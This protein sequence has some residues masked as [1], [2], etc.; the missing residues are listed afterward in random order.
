MWHRQETDGCG[1]LWV[2][3]SCFTLYTIPGTTPLIVPYLSEVVTWPLNMQRQ[4]N[5]KPVHVESG[6]GQGGTGTDFSPHV[7]T[8]SI[9]N[10]Y[11]SVCVLNHKN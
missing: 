4:V 9:L 1:Q 8:I 11:I 10:D 7:V 2:R 5:S 6:H 3:H